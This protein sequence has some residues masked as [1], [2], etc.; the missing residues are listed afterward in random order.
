MFLLR[1]PAEAVQQWEEALRLRP[2]F[3]GLR[4]RI[5]QARRA[6]APP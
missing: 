3:P 1:R 4:E 6:L 2:D 5:E